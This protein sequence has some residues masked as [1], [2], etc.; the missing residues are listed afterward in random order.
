MIRGMGLFHITTRDAWAQAERDGEYRAPSLEL[1]GFIHLSEDL[2]L[3][4]SAERY[5]NGQTG[6]VVLALRRHKL[7][8]ELRYEEV[9]GESY[10]HLYGPLN[11]DAVVEAVD[12]P[13]GQDGGFRVPEPWRA[14]AHYFGRRDEYDPGP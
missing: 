11:L 12:L 5:F 6:L 2:Q 8:A 10:P 7:T 3:L 9:H 14:W 1:E 4:P 13:D